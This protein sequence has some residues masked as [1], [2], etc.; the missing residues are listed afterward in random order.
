MILVMT[1]TFSLFTILTPLRSKEATELVK[2]VKNNLILH[3]GTPMELHF[4]NE[5]GFKSSIF[6]RFAEENQIKLHFSM[7]YTSY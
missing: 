5:L 6:E 4:D 3:Y 7:P 2:A 1:D